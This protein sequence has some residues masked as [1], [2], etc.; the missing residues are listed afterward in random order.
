MIAVTVVLISIGSV[1]GVAVAHLIARLI[2][3][4]ISS[5]VTPDEFEI[6][7]SSYL[8]TRNKTCHIC[9]EKFSLFNPGYC[10]SFCNTDL[11]PSH[12]NCIIDCLHRK[13]ECPVCRSKPSLPELPPN[14]EI[15]I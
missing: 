13:M 15:T 5:P 14:P 3:N 11:H 12:W 4:F 1:L 8:N 2:S 9:L 10:I 6:V 7:K